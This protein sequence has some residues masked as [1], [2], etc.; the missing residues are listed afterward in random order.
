MSDTADDVL[1]DHRP[2]GVA[3]ITI[4]RP[5]QMNAISNGVR[6][7]LI[8]YI[9][10]A[11]ADDDVRCVVL[12]GAGRAFCAGVDV[13]RL[14]DSAAT[15]GATKRR[16]GLAGIVRGLRES[17]MKTIHA[18]H[19]MPKPT[20]A[21]VN[22]YAIGAG[23]AYALACDL[24]IAS[25]D[26]RFGTGFTRLAVSG[27]NGT[28][29]FLQRLVGPAKALEL[30]LTGEVVDG[31]R[32]VELGMA[33]RLEPA[34]GFMDRVLAFASTL[35]A[36]PPLAHARMKES[37]HLG[38]HSDLKTLL[39]HEALAINLSLIT[40]DHKAAITALRDGTTATFVGR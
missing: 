6:E 4:N 9:S 22:G 25:T 16:E 5:E 17:Q 38:E 20:L 40:E 21:A 24:R 34:D 37:F 19:T 27:D 12:T 28:S 31:A 29:W 8:R 18:L 26:A 23:L 7:L 33:N 10:T 11:A 36:G 30:F 15:D 14:A 1:Y 39:D 35:A 2:D 32:A 3:I 13:K